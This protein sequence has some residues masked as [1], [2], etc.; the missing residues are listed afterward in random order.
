MRSTSQFAVRGYLVALLA[1]LYLPI[2]IMIAMAFN[3]FKP[4]RAP[5]PLFLDVVRAIIPQ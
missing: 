3:E 5:F 1:F 4:L 2:A